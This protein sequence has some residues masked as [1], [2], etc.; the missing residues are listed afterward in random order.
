MMAS[1]IWVRQCLV[2][3]SD[4]NCTPRVRTTGSNNH[5]KEYYSDVRPMLCGGRDQSCGQQAIGTS[6]T[7]MLQN[8]PRTWSRHFWQKPPVVIILT[9]VS[10]YV[11]CKDESEMLKMRI[12]KLN[13]FLSCFNWICNLETHEEWRCTIW[14]CEGSQCIFWMSWKN[15]NLYKSKLNLIR[16]QT[17]WTDFRKDCAVIGKHKPESALFLPRPLCCSLPQMRDKNHR[18]FLLERSGYIPS[19]VL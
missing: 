10:I 18:N 19:L 7:T 16:S 3:P 8:I 11:W 1:S 13:E 5:Q 6:I 17:V 15:K 12:L 14:M 9:N 2:L 4:F